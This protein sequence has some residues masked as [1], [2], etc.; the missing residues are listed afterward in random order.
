MAFTHSIDPAARL[1]TI[2][3]IAGDLLAEAKAVTERVLADPR[4]NDD[5][6]L[7]I[8]PDKGIAPPGPDSVL[9]LADLLRLL[10]SR[11]RGR[12]AIV[13]SVS[14]LMPAATMISLMGGR[15]SLGNREEVQAFV[16]ESEGRSW[17]LGAGRPAGH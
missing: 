17:V 12:I 2:R 16:T 3:G 4:I 5:F 11:I 10:R 8:V 1:V 7:M 6:R 15:P 14:S 9:G 13:T